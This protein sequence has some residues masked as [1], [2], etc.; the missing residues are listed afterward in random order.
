MI[1][2]ALAVET[3]GWT[4][5]PSV[6]AHRLRRR[7]TEVPKQSS[8]PHTAL[9]RIGHAVE[10]LGMK[11]GVLSLDSVYEYERA[12]SENARVQLLQVEGLVVIPRGEIRFRT[13]RDIADI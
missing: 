3:L 6:F 5:L 1:G 12:I 2:V 10:I 8:S 13:V 4:D 7:W 9:S 11:K